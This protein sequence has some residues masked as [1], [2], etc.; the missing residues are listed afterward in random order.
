[1]KPAARAV[2][3]VAM[4]G[5]LCASS[6]AFA[7]DSAKSPAPKGTSNALRVVVDP[8]SGKL[9]APT[10]E[11]LQAMIAAER[12]AS[13]ARTTARA[14]VAAST[15]EQILPDTKVVKQHANG[16]VSA[17]LSQDSLSMV[18]LTTDAN[19][20]THLAHKGEER[21]VAAEEK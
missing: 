7:D 19:G 15:T 5:T 14:A 17:R 4:A 21:K 11:E 1:M 8:E 9:R 2:A 3:L 20:T 10:P 18:T 13:A 12:G 16:M 6:L